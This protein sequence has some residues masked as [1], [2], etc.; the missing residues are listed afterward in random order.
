MFVKLFGAAI[1]VVDGEEPQAAGLRLRGRKGL[2]GE[3]LARGMY[4]KRRPHA[5][6]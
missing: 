5:E 2:V 6:G 3:Q 1:G 4:V